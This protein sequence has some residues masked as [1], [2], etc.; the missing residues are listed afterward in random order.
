MS[1]KGLAGVDQ[2]LDN[3]HT[4][5][6]K[7]LLEKG[8]ILDAVDDFGQTPLIMA[9]IKGY[10]A[11]SEL[12]LV[13]GASPALTNDSIPPIIWA[14]GTDQKDLVE[15]LLAHSV[16]IECRDG[17][18]GHTPLARAA[19]Q[20]NKAIVQFPLE[21]GADIESK[22][23]NGLTPLLWA[24]WKGH[25]AVIRLLFDHNADIKT[26]DEQYG[27]TALAWAAREAKYSMSEA[28][29]QLLVDRGANIESKSDNGQTAL[30][31]AAER[32]RKGVV[33]VLLDN[34]AIAKLG[35]GDGDKDLPLSTTNEN[36]EQL[37]ELL[38]SIHRKD[39]KSAMYQYFLHDD[40]LP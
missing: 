19:N 21:K 23:D 26:K 17:D 14:G 38:I 31:L 5:V 32:G 18:W 16:S 35:D 2:N 8:V 12:L 4:A 13:N 37:V 11:I 33:K 22:G 9:A 15:L 24:A 30:E 28:V 3:G 25:E 10:F 29:A 7:E 40:H 27:R 1:A 20:G 6:V 39:T 36:T 34:R